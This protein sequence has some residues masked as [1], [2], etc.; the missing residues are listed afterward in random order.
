MA[1]HNF[2]N[3]MSMSFSIDET[4]LHR[5]RS[6]TGKYTQQSRNTTA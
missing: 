3:R 1:V 5:W 2:V 4:L 6:D